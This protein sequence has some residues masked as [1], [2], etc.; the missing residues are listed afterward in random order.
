MRRR[1]TSPFLAVSREASDRPRAV[2]SPKDLRTEPGPVRFIIIALAVTFLTVFVVLPLVVVFASAFSK[3]IGAYFCRAGRAGGAVGD[4]ADAAGGGDLGHPQSGVRR[5]RGLGDREIRFP[6][7]DLP[8]HA[9]RPAVL[10]QPGDLGPR[11]RA[12][13]RRAGLF[14]HLAAGAR[15][16][17]PVRGAR[18]CARDHLRDVSV[19]RPRADPADA[20]AGHAGGR[21]RDLA[22]RVR[23][24]DLLPRHSAQYQMGPVVWRTAVQRARHG[25]VRR[26]VGGVGPYPRR[27]QHHAAAGRD[28][29][30]RVSIRGVVCDCLAAGDAGADHAG[31]EDR[32]RTAS[33]RRTEF[34]SDH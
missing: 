25:R 11:L 21:G 32:S 26:G 20:G 7:Q 14:G 5:D 1:R 6:R 27:D 16:P 15:H 18:H 30:Q 34:R 19:R 33:G 29:L 31:R 3:G 10:G 23:P 8:D 9:D 24:A 28:P 22:R 2:A 13:V 17:H 4:Q 12:A